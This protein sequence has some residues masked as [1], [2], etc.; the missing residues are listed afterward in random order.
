MS[1]NKILF[2]DSLNLKF[3]CTSLLIK[4]TSSLSK[5]RWPNLYTI[6]HTLHHVS[7]IMSLARSIGQIQESYF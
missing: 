4:F 7:L 2:L 1:F 3:G 6:V 5:K